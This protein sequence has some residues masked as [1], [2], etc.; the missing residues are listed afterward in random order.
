NMPLPNTD[1]NDTD[2]VVTQ[3]EYNFWKSRFGATSGSG[4]GGVGGLAPASSAVPEPSAG[5]M[6]CVCGLGV[7][8]G[9]L[10]RRDRRRV[11]I[12]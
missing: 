1:P 3:A 2:G 8:G 12:R 5:L 9:K 7:M 10:V 6:A 4:S 11:R